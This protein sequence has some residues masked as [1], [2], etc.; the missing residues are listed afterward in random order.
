[1]HAIP[2]KK[3]ACSVYTGH[4]SHV[5]APVVPQPR[6]SSD[7]SPMENFKTCHWPSDSHGSAS[8]LAQLVNSSSQASGS[9]LPAQALQAGRNVSAP[10]PRAADW[11]SQ[12]PC[13]VVPCP[14]CLLRIT[15]GDHAEALIAAARHSL[16]WKG[17]T[18]DH[19]L[20][21]DLLRSSAVWIIQDMQRLAPSSTG[22]AASS[23]APVPMA[24]DMPGSQR[25]SP[26]GLQSGPWPAWQDASVAT[27]AQ[28]PP[29]PPPLP[30]PTCTMNA[31]Q[32]NR[33]YIFSVKKGEGKKATFEPYEADVQTVLND[34]VENGVQQV[35]V[36]I[37]GYNYVIE[38]KQDCLRQ[39]NAGT[40][41]AREVRMERC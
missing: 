33:K 7:S 26:S 36:A 5:V 22:T 25:T 24:V 31:C 1:M 2:G 29:P 19:H 40:N 10:S 30:P 41:R 28:S 21:T 13:T 23:A 34:A 35:S 9:I 4:S 37:M 17:D 15:H 12:G 3:N 39:I 8:T 16:S 14:W 11:L 38:L 18:P 20:A 32:Q 6:N 27:S